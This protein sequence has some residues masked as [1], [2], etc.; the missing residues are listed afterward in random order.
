MPPDL[1]IGSNPRS[2]N[3]SNPG[4]RG[5]SHAAGAT[6]YSVIIPAYNT[7]VTLDACLA[8]LAR[9]TV[10]PAVYEVIVVDDGSTDDTAAVARRHGAILLALA[11][12]G[13]A[14][15]RNAGAR[16]A[17]GDIL[18]F[19]D[20]D[21]EPLTDWIERMA[22]P[23]ADPGV[24]GV[25]GA[26]LTRQS[27]LVARFAQAEY[28][29]KYRRLARQDDID[30]VDTYAAA[31]RRDLFLAHGGFDPHFVLDE[32]QE[33][34]FRLARAGHRLV[35]AP[36]ARVYHRHQRTAWGYFRR[37]LGIGRWKVAVHAR[38]PARALRDS[39]TPW[40][41]KLQILLVPATVAAA[42]AA[43]LGRLRWRAV[44]ALA[45]LGP[46][47]ALPLAGIARRQGWPVALAAPFLALLRA[48]ALALGLAWGLLAAATR[49]RRQ[50]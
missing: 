27:S 49:R 39:Y 12:A 38:Y 23:F 15:A 30:F 24:A 44:A 3:G 42:A 19:T 10:P 29:E 48:A 22:A 8:A 13:A 20:A 5:G 32:D 9:Q 33:F 37:K 17:R 28:E 31:Y 40:T 26:Y 2:S 7:A 47:S 34:S 25:K 4:S 6:T 50:P 45:V 35:F 1:Q 46:A 18:F 16:R 41:Q 21:C 36:R 43:M 11:H 14:A